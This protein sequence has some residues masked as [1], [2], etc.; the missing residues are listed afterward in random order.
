MDGESNETAALG[1]FK[2]SVYLVKED[3]ADKSGNS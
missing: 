2:C 3:T 1:R